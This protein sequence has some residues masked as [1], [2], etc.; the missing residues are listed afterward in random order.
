MRQTRQVEDNR[1]PRSWL[2]GRTSQSVRHGGIT[3]PDGNEACHL[4]SRWAERQG[5]GTIPS[6][7]WQFPRLVISLVKKGRLEFD[8]GTRDLG[9]HLAETRA[10]HLDL[11]KNPLESPEGAEQ[12]ETRNECRGSKPL[13][14]H[15]LWGPCAKRVHPDRGIG[16]SST[17][18]RPSRN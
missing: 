7:S 9:V 17:L 14:H 15:R 12:N 6:T 2:F 1:D 8:E 18:S 3:A 10:G 16:V 5:T 13:G 11:M 4:A